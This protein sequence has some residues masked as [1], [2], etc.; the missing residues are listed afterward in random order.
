[1]KRW[2][3]IVGVL[4]M[5]LLLAGCDAFGQRAGVG[6]GVTRQVNA[7]VYIE[8]FDAGTDKAMLNDLLTGEGVTI[9]QSNTNQPAAEGTPT[10]TGP[11]VDVPVSVTPI[12]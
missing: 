12:P 10:A 3:L 11:D 9:D 2:I 4:A 6:Q 8:T 5:L 7:M 1:M